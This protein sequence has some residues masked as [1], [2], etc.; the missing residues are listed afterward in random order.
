MTY[1]H[2]GRTIY[3]DPSRAWIAGVCAGF[4][5]YFGS[6]PLT[7]RV[8]VLLLCTFPPL[9]VL[10]CLGYAVAAF[11]LPVKPIGGP[12]EAAAQAFSRSMN[13]KPAETFGDVRHRMR[14]LETRLRRM[15]AYV[16]SPEYE[17]DR[18]IRE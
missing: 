12:A 4:A 5:D 1:T 13:R 7:I 3:R 17:I 8:I 6:R 16:T 2:D 9:G 18:G 15:E 11:R 10:I 14:E